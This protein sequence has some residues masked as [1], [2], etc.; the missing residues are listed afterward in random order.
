MKPASGAVESGHCDEPPDADVPLT[1]A[2]PPTPESPFIG[3]EPLDG[4]LPLQAAR[5]KDNNRT[6]VVR[7]EGVINRP[8]VINEFKIHSLSQARCCP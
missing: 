1:L 5:P 3:V 6:V 8:I 4:E 7:F 2:A